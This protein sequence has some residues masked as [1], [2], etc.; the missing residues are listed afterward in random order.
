MP[1]RA[2]QH[3]KQQQKQQKQQPQDREIKRYLPPVKNLIRLFT[4][5]L[6]F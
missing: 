1:Y 4:L 3:V 2:L 6:I 5:I